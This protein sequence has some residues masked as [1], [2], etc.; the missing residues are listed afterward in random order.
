MKN[1]LMTKVGRVF[2]RAGLQIKKHSPEILMVAGIAGTVAS[3]VMACKATTKINDILEPT[4]QTIDIVHKGMED[5]NV[6]GTEYTKEDGVKDLT[7]IYT[8]TAVK[9]AKLYA[10]SIIL[11]TLSITSIVAGHSILK[12]RNIA[13]AAAYA[14]VDKGF[15]DYRKNVVDRFGA[16][17]DKELRYNLKAKEIEEITTDENGNEKVEKKIINE[18]GDPSDY[19]EYARFYDDGNTGWSKNPELNLMFLRRQQDYANE[20]LKSKGYLFLNE[21]Y[22][23]LGIPRSKAG[24]VVGWIYDKK[25][26]KGDNYVDFGIYNNKE[27]NRNFVNGY[28]PTILLD[29]NVDGVIYDMLEQ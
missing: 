11:G 25:N 1:E 15:K 26:P 8:Q 17:L 9:L 23:M 2:S 13:L 19:S 22:D 6:N 3:T 27:V 5:G 18:V 14:V 24:Q 16:E 7:I 28:E 10:P 4:K 20:M 12:K 21:V 29:F